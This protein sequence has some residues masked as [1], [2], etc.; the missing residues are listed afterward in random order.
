MG[1][2]QYK[3]GLLAGLP[4]CLGYLPVSF[5]FGLMAVQGGIPV[6]LAVFI[7]LSNVTSAGQFA[8]TT[9]ILADA[10]LFEIGL[11]TF[12]INLRYMLM[13]L[14]LS[15]KLE[16]AVTTGK[17]LLIGFGITD[18]IFAIASMKDGKVSASYMYG[19][20]TLPIFGWTLGTLL[21]GCTSGI[22]PD[23]LQN[24]MGIALY[25][26]FIAIIIPPAK[27]SRPVIAVILL[28]VLITCVLKY[29]PLFQFI[30]SGFQMIIA[31]VVSSSLMA[32]FVP[33]KEE[34]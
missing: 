24:A 8:G 10:G 33:V 16:P 2:S 7:S 9:L 15:Q 17:R 30:S 27:K 23:F 29:V 25:T 1:H 11:T 6:W 19:L 31:A 4:I 14:S 32:V 34:N 20:M 26:M 21:G 22:L 28:A 18:E 5:T 3:K 12:V 13:S